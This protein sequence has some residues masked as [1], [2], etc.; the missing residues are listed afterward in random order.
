MPVRPSPLMLRGERSSV[1]VE[2]TPV[3]QQFPERQAGVLIEK[4]MMSVRSSRLYLRNA[5]TIFSAAEVFAP[6]VGERF[7][8]QHQPGVG[9]GSHQAQIGVQR[10]DVLSVGK[11]DP[12]DLLQRTFL[13]VDFGTLVYTVVVYDQL[14]DRQS[15]VRPFPSRRP[16]PNRLW[17]TK[18]VSSAPNWVPSSSRGCAYHLGLSEGRGGSCG[19]AGRRRR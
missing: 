17:R 15:A 2:D 13:H 11:H 19:R 5:L 16:R 14:V 7:H 1:Q 18:Q 8:F 3:G 6:K 10:R 12:G 9:F 4:A